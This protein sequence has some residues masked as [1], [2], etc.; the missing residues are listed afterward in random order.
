MED[1]TAPPPRITVPQPQFRAPRQVS[2]PKPPPQQE[3]ELG[4]DPKIGAD[5]EDAY[6]L[7]ISEARLIIETVHKTRQNES[8]RNVLGGG[9]VHN[10]SEYALPS[11]VAISSMS[12]EGR[13]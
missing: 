9:R 3:E 11:A 10:D 2:R 8:S 7:S 4:A 6:A 13:G 12:C 5:F 1:E